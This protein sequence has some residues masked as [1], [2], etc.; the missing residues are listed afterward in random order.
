MPASGRQVVAAAIGVKP[1]Q[2]HVQSTRIGGGFGRRL[3]S[4]YAAEAAVVSKAIG[5]P[6]QVVESRAGDLQHDYYRPLA[7]QRIRAGADDRGR[8]VAWDHVVASCSR[9]AYRLDARPPHSTE[10][11]GC[12]VGAANDGGGARSRPGADA[13]RQR[14]SPLR[15]ARARACPTGAWRAPSHMAV[16]FAVES[17]ID[18][19]ARLAK[20][21]AV[22]VR[23]DLL[24]ETAD[25]PK[26]PE[27]YQ[28]DPARMKRVLAG[29]RRTRRRRQRA[30][31][32]G[33]GRGMAGHFT[34]GSYC[35]HVVELS[36]DDAKRVVVHRVTSVVDCGQPV[37]L[38]GVEAQV[39]GGVV[40]ALGAA[41]YGEVPIADGRAQ[42][43]NFDR[44]RL[45]RQREAPRAIDVVVLPSHESPTGMGEIAL[46]PLAPAVAN[47]IAA[48]TG[49]R[50]RQMPFARDGYALS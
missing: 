31:P 29:R 5:A 43:A 33:R 44:Y 35:A 4:D 10:A 41:F 2:V 36:I 18:E 32:E 13:D 7:A 20:R 22:D 40:D 23:L 27:G 28:Y 25:V 16:A 30:R 1:E 48:L 17:T 39:E 46:P 6:V 9:G 34:F 45:I 21:S 14:P 26:A 50:L 49:V 42:V 37:N 24:G 8:I 47:A 19:I 38:L 11:Y 12:Y 3:L 15:P